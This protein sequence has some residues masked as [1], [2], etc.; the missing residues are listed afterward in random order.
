[1]LMAH[2]ILVSER[3]YCR[4]TGKPLEI[5]RKENGADSGME[6][7]LIGHSSEV[8]EVQS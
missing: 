1:M 3:S 7:R 6:L 4:D 5:S 8:A 2:I